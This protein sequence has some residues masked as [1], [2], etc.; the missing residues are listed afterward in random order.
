MPFKENKTV[1]CFIDSNGDEFI[2]LNERF[3][4]EIFNDTND[5]VICIS[6]EDIS[7]IVE[8]LEAVNESIV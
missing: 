5:S 4:I 8:W 2:F 3:Y 6:K 7:Q 1:R